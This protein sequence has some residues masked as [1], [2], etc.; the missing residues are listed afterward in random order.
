V[1]NV[2]FSLLTAAKATSLKNLGVF[3]EK[4]NRLA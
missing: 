3:D 2:F 1:T 4:Q